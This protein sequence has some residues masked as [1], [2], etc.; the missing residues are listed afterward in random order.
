MRA[1]GA[2]AQPNLPMANPDHEAQQPFAPGMSSCLS[3]TA[4]TNIPATTSLAW[5]VPIHTNSILLLPHWPSRR[6]FSYVRYDRGSCTYPAEYSPQ[7]YLI[8]L[9]DTRR[10]K[11]SCCRSPFWNHLPGIPCL[12][13]LIGSGA[14]GLASSY[15]NRR[16]GSGLPSCLWP[17]ACSWNTTLRQ[18]VEVTQKAHLLSSP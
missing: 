13:L 15:T 2:L 10:C 4:Q 16:M 18:D 11:M 12:A 5:P 9:E 8:T 14:M 1:P 6:E 17:T 3:P 7:P